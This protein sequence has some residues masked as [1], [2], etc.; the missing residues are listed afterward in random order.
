VPG[1]AKFGIFE[2]DLRRNELRRKGVRIKLQQQ[3]FEILRLL[4][5]HRGE[6]V[7]RDL[8]QQTLWPDGRFVDFER[9]INSAIMRLRQ[10]LR[11][12]AGTP[13]Y[14]ETVARLGYRLIP[15]VLDD[16]TG[17]KEVRS[18]AIL[19][20]QD[21]SAHPD[22]QYFVDG[23]TDA[24]ITAM[25][26]GSDLR[27]VSRPSMLRYKDSQLGI[28]QIA[29][30]LDVQALVEGSILR[31]GDRIRISARLLD[32]VEDRHLW[33]QTYERDLKDILFLQ[34]E[35]ASA[36]VGSVTAAIKHGA[37][38]EA[39]RQVNPRAYESLLRGNFLLSMRSPD[40]MAKAAECYENAILLEP[41]WAPPYAMLADCCRA[42]VFYNYPSSK[43]LV[44]QARAMAEKAIRLDPNNARAMAVAGALMALHDW[45]WAEGEEKIRAAMRLDPQSSQ[46][47]HL[48]SQVLLYMGRF[49]EALLHAYLALSIEPT[50]LFLWSHRAQILLFSR[51]FHECLQESERLLDQF[52]SF[53]MG[54]VHYGATLIELGRPGEALPAFENAF[55]STGMPVALFGIIHSYQELGKSQEAHRYLDRLR[56]MHRDGACSPAMLAWAYLTTGA[57]EEAFSLLATAVSERDTR[58][59]LFIHLPQFDCVRKDERFSRILRR[60]NLQQQPS[61]LLADSGGSVRRSLPR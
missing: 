8:I 3:P 43:R 37:T 59:S 7:P 41:Y 1:S 50:S 22:G 25:A 56:Q 34:Q 6:L 42:Q 39:A 24:L 40:Q 52:P 2:L 26:L 14:I 51:R 30:E 38:R 31:S 10:A 45:Q 57:V 17:H 36:I 58:L 16:S 5:E 12:S 54:R 44:T 46:M 13:T 9:S 28:R 53:A 19:P 49:E 18:I 35:I 60:M 27:V 29:K 48:Y 15:P 11:E 20:L 47:E 55:A 61:P 32:A 4:V 21:L 33:A 23:L